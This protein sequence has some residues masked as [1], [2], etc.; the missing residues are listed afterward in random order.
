M[1]NINKLGNVL[2]KILEVLHW[3]GAG[4]LL[5]A[6]VCVVAA[7][8][9]LA[10]FVGLDTYCCCGADLNVYGFEVNV[11]VVGGNVDMKSFMLFAIGGVIILAVMAMVFRNLHRVFK[12][13]ESETPFQKGTVC[14][15]KRIGFLSMAVPVIGLVMSVLI[16]LI[17]GVDAVEISVNTTG[18][19]MGIIILCL[20]Q[21]F[22]HGAELEKDV[23]G[24]V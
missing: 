6:T 16:R 5:A 13:A 22:V 20:T 10:H 12:K 24:L 2:T 3:V 23:D 8:G 11:P 19:F 9:W 1:K 14:A 15:M 17:L 4:L 7:P 21:F 18:I